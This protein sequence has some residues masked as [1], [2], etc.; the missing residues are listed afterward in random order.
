MANVAASIDWPSDPVQYFDTTESTLN[1]Y[2]S[3]PSYPWGTLPL[4]ATK[5][6]ADVMDAAPIGGPSGGGTWGNFDHIHLVGRALSALVDIGSI[7]VM[8]LLGSYLFN[9]R[10]GL[11]A[12]FLLSVT[13]LNIQYAHYFVVDSFLAFLSLLSLYFAVRAAKEGGRLNFVLAGV[14]FGAALAS[15]GSAAPLALIIAMAAAIQA[16][17]I[18]KERWTASEGETTPASLWSKE[19]REPLFGLALAAVAAFAVFRVAQPYAFDGLFPWNISDIWRTD[20]EAVYDRSTGVGGWPPGVRWIGQARWLY[21]L[22]NMLVWGMGIPLF[23][24][25]AGGLLYAAWRVARRGEIILLLLLTWIVVIFVWQGGL[26]ISYMRYLLPIYPP[27]VLLAAYGLLAL[28]QATE[29]KSVPA[30]L[31]R[32]WPSLSSYLRVAGRVTVAAVVVLTLLWAFAFTNVYRSPLTRVE[33]S[34]WI[35]ANVPAG[36]QIANP[37]WDDTLPLNVDGQDAGQNYELLQLRPYDLLDSDD[38]FPEISSE[39]SGTYRDD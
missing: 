26:F 25:A 16:W 21:P 18:I 5:A 23:L 30:R 22:H 2:N 14:M 36:S 34:R 38:N 35:Y 27:L 39:T 31:Q 32:L 10:V 3:F 8:F 24:A 33:A 7:I 28:W 12:A 17:P 1:P 13:V 19:L 11:L 6:V 15:K 37:H 20:V 9:R 29:W 4:F